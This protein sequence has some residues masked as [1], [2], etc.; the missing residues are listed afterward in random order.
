MLHQ[1]LILT[2][3]VIIYYFLH[4]NYIWHCSSPSYK[5]LPTSL[6]LALI[7]YLPRFFVLQ[8]DYIIYHHFVLVLWF[9]RTLCLWGIQ[10]ALSENK[11][12]ACFTT[13]RKN[14]DKYEWF[15]DNGHYQIKQAQ[16]CVHPGKK[17]IRAKMILC[18]P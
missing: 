1:I 18:Y 7:L 9:S 13:L 16:H 2:L 15:N 4:S 6:G 5:F 11:S 8:L 17:K 3:T 10:T 14:V 12:L